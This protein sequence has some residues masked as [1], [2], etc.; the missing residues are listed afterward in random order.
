MANK[1]MICPNLIINKIKWKQI[2][3]SWKNSRLPHALLFHGP[4]GVGKE[5]HA[6]ELSALLNC[7]NIIKNRACGFCPSCKKVKSFQH[8]NIKVIIPLPRGKISSK[9][10]SVVKA[11]K[12]EKSLQ[13]YFDLLRKKITEPYSYINIKGANTILIN[14]IREIKN[15]ISMSLEKNSW[16][17]ILIFQAEKLCTP[18][19]DSAHSLLKVLEEPPKQTIFIL[20]SSKQ[21]IIINTIQSRCQNIY[22]PAIS[23]NILMDYLLKENQTPEKASIIA[24]ISLGNMSLCHSLI[25]DYDAVLNNLSTFLEACFSRNPSNWNNFIDLSARLKMKDIHLLEQIF[26][27]AIIFFRDLLYYSTTNLN[28]NIIYKNYNEK[29]NIICNKY[30]NGD[31]HKCI[32]HIENTYDYILRNGYLPLM[33]INLFI[34]IQKSLK[35]KY[36]KTIDLS[37]WVS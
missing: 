34:D 8:E 20:V 28:K 16:K 29:I 26:N 25:N 7:N 13:E 12:N 30:P 4:Q 33:V 9:N 22:F 32:E 21:N 18:N 10:D 27:S 6:I 17:V 11:F 31:W 1:K 36:H 3:N 15:N 37:E 19:P 5:G 2:I 23:K 24:N 35:N 14:S